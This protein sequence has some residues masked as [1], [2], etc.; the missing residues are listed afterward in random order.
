MVGC[1]GSGSDTD[2][3]YRKYVGKAA[4]LT[5]GSVGVCFGSHLRLTNFK[6]ASDPGER[7]E[8][9]KNDPS[10]LPLG[11]KNPLTI[12]RVWDGDAE[13]RWEGMGASSETGT[14]WIPFSQLTANDPDVRPTS[15]QEQ[16]AKVPLTQEIKTVSDFDHSEFCERY[17]CKL[18][19]DSYASHFKGRT[20]TEYSYDTTVDQLTVH[21]T[22]EGQIVA[23]CALAFSG[24]E[25]LSSGEFAIIST[26][27]RSTDQRLEHEKARIFVKQ[28]VENTI[29]S[30]CSMFDAPNYLVDGQFLIRAGKRG[31]DQVV[32]FRR[33][34]M[35]AE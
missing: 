3:A 34:G 5:E 15:T 14:C 4:R 1:A 32:H 13:V 11:T 20:Y 30:K 35:F 17:H 2:P 27:L 6:N 12:L 9:M 7:W 25:R 29:C 16:S 28:N 8:A 22:A 21:V 23:M 19:S 10:L 26:L 33:V 31:S 24:R 18:K